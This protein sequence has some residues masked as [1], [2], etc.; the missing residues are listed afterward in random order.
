MT[1]Y[2]CKA[3]VDAPGFAVKFFG[4]YR[5]AAD[6]A[7]TLSKTFKNPHEA[8][9]APD[10]E[11][12]VVRGADGRVFDGDGLV[13]RA[14]ANLLVPWAEKLPKMAPVPPDYDY[15]NF[16]ELAHPVIDLGSAATLYNM[17]GGTTSPLYEYAEKAIRKYNR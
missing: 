7:E 2:I 6:L 12:Y 11:G 10:F 8:L 4:T 16:H 14:V 13:P 5:D 9:K 1:N 3:V 17:S 15:N